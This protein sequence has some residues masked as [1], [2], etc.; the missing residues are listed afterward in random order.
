M[1]E[2]LTI[3]WDINSS[4]IMY[5]SY[6]YCHGYSILINSTTNKQVNIHGVGRVEKNNYLS[7]E[8]IPQYVLSQQSCSQYF[9]NNV[10]GKLFDNLKKEP[11]VS[12]RA[13]NIK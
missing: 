2:Y 11:S 9:T 8:G 10:C 1:Q 12:Y 3:N 6:L 4:N 7:E 5:I 13:M